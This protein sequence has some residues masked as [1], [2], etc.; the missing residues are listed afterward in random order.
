MRGPHGKAWKWQ[1]AGPPRPCAPQ[2]RPG[3]AQVIG[4]RYRQ[5]TVSPGGRAATG[6]S[7]EPT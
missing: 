1:P 7:V 5:G 3:S 4:K 2:E 6:L